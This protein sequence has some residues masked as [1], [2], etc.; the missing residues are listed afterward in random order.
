ML[1]SIFGEKTKPVKDT[2]YFVQLLV[3]YDKGRAYKAWRAN[4]PLE[5]HYSSRLSIYGRWFGLTGK[6][7]CLG[8]KKIIDLMMGKEATLTYKEWLALRTNELGDIVKEIE[9]EHLLPEKFILQEQ[10]FLS[11]GQVNYTPEVKR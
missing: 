7:K 5:K 1:R 11:K 9:K 8:A 6:P 4:V 3:A 2:K 10:A